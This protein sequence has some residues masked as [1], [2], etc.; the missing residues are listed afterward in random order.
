[1][2]ADSHVQHYKIAIL[3][4]AVRTPIVVNLCLEHIA[5]VNGVANRIA[6]KSW[7]ASSYSLHMTYYGSYTAHFLVWCMSVFLACRE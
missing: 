7:R 6:H 1:M 5:S 3:Y 4:F 2:L